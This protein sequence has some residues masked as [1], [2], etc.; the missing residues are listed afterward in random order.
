MWWQILWLNVKKYWKIVA[1][2]LIAIV[3]FI[4]FRRRESEFIKDIKAINDAHVDEL[5]KIEKAREEE[6]KRYEENERKLQTMLTLI[7]KQY[8]AQLKQLDDKKRVEVEKLVKTYKDDPT[9]LAKRLS[10]VAGFVVILPEV[11]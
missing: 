10:A 6:K 11:K 2:V 3:G 5:K 1:L 7:Q 8:D 9:E 4:V